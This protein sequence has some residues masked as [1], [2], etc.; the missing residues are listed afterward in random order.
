MTVVDACTAIHDIVYKSF[1]NNLLLSFQTA[2]IT[3]LLD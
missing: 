3:A 2:T 1:D